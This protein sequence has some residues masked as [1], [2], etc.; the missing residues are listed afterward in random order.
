M[1]QH[2]RRV[3]AF[4]DAIGWNSQIDKNTADLKSRQAYAGFEE[5][6]E[7]QG[8]K[9]PPTFEHR[10]SLVED[11]SVVGRGERLARIREAAGLNAR[12][13]SRIVG[14]LPSDVTEWERNLRPIPS[15]VVP[16]IERACKDTLI[17]TGMAA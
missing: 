2:P 10:R 11:D 13:L 6:C 3:D 7:K 16:A 4:W 15:S 14:M 5:R 17:P 8:L 12:Q 1:I 9:P